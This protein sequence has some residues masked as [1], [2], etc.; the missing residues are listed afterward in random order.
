MKKSISDGI[1]V[2]LYDKFSRWTESFFAT[3]KKRVDTLDAQWDERI[4]ASSSV[5]VHQLL[6]QCYDNTKTARL[7]VAERLFQIIAYR[8]VGEGTTSSPA[9]TSQE[10]LRSRMQWS[11]KGCSDEII[12]YTEIIIKGVLEQTISHI[13]EIVWAIEHTSTDE[14]YGC[15]LQ[16][17]SRMR[18]WVDSCDCTFLLYCC[19]EYKHSSV[20]FFIRFR[21]GERYVPINGFTTSGYGILH[22]IRMGSGL[23]CSVIT[24]PN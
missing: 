17:Y 21:Y 8:P 6:L 14:N 12:E 24:N 20:G 1:A 10:L 23:W 16:W 5:W 9:P 18:S 13:I 2:R 7:H 19:W 15:F 22:T 11:R 3:M 4:R